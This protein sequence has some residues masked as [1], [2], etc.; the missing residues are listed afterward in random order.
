MN[1]FDKGVYHVHATSPHGINI[2]LNLLRQAFEARGP[3]V[4]FVFEV[5]SSQMHPVL[6]FLQK[7]YVFKHLLSTSHQSTWFV[8]TDKPTFGKGNTHYTYTA[9][10]VHNIYTRA[11]LTS[12][13][14]KLSSILSAAF[15][16]YGNEFLGALSDDYHQC[17]C[18]ARL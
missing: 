11:P 4:S 1:V 15:G 12:L 14:Q 18:V 6:S 3:I 2:S 8:H 13:P 9:C 16:G 17:L 10:F 7:S 5:D